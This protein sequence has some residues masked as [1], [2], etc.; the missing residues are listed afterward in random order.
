MNSAMPPTSSPD[1]NDC[2]PA[3]PIAWARSTTPGP[4]AGNWTTWSSIAAPPN[5]NATAMDM[6]ISVRRSRISRSWLTAAAT[7]MSISASIP[8]SSFSAMAMYTAVNALTA[9][10]VRCSYA[11]HNST[12]TRTTGVN[13][14]SQ[15]NR[16]SKAVSRQADA[17]PTA[18]RMV[19]HA[20]RAGRWTILGQKLAR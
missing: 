11:T 4:A 12:A 5:A 14:A 7:P 15:T 1:R 6:R 3:M 16:G 10:E 18:S 19:S 2:A 17:M 13:D 8:T 20:T 9:R